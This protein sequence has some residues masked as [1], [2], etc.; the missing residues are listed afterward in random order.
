MTWT[1]EA[2]D[3]WYVENSRSPSV[4]SVGIAKDGVIKAIAVSTGDTDEGDY[5]VAALNAYEA[6]PSSQTAGLIEAANGLKRI[7]EEI[8]GTMNHGTWRDDK[9]RRLKDT[10]EWVRLYNAVHD[11]SQKVTA[12]KAQSMGKTD[13]LL[14]D[15]PQEQPVGYV[16]LGELNQLKGGVSCVDLFG[17]VVPKGFK[18]VPLYERPPQEHV[19]LTERQA[20]SLA[21][22]VTEYVE[23]GIRGGT[24]W[25]N[26]LET[27]IAA[28]LRRI[29]AIPPV[30]EM[31]IG[32]NHPDAKAVDRFAV[33]MKAKLA[34]KRAEGRGGW[35]NPDECS[36]ALLSELLREHVAKGD[37][38]D[39]G[40]LAMMIHQRGGIIE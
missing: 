20:A 39:V 4:T 30:V 14:N 1:T 33:A 5:I 6:S 13:S 28:R 37:P 12:S 32:A 8:D 29:A 18:M 24:D 40:N 21:A 26:G 38:V 27:I 15:L 35:D 3:P 25:R 7:V 34:K 9:G 36:I 16:T 17:E 2:Q 22:M 31:A 19:E 11:A 23:G 10:P